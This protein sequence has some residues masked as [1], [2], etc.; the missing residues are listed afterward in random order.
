MP[1][2]TDIVKAMKSNRSSLPVS[3]ILTGELSLSNLELNKL[4]FDGF[5][6]TGNGTTQDIVTGIASEDVNWYV[7]V[8]YSIGDIRFTR[9]GFEN[10]DGTGVDL[11]AGAFTLWECN[12][13]HTSGTT[14]GT[15]LG[16][17]YWT[18][19]ADG[20]SKRFNSSK[21]HIKSRSLATNNFVFDSIRGKLNETN[22]NT[23]DAETVLVSSLTSFNATGFSVGLALGVNENLET[24]IAYQTLYT[25]IVCGVTN[26]GKRYIEAF[27]PVTNETMI[28][29]QGSGIDGHEIPQST[30]VA[31]DLVHSKDLDDGLNDWFVSGVELNGNYLATN[32]TASILTTGVTYEDNTITLTAGSSV[33][34]SGNTCISYG[35]AKSKTWT[36]VEYTGTGATGNFVRTL[37][38]EGN[39]RRPA[40]VIIKAVSAVGSWAVIDNKRIDNEIFLDLSNAEVSTNTL[41][42]VY[43]GFNI[44][45]TTSGTNTL[46]T[47]YIALVEFDT[48]ATG[49]DGSYFDNPTDTTN[50]QLLNGNVSFSNGYNAQ[51]A[52]NT[53]LPLNATVTPT[54]GF[55]AGN[56]YIKIKSDGTSIST[57]V[58]PTFGKISTLSDY[59]LNGVWYDLNGTPLVDIVTYADEVVEANLNGEPVD[60]HNDFI[61][62][63]IVENKILSKVAEIV[64]LTGRW[65]E[66]DLEF[67]EV[68]LNNGT[69][70]FGSNAD[71]FYGLYPDGRAV[72]GH[73]RFDTVNATTASGVLFR[74]AFTNNWTFPFVFSSEAIDAKVEISD[75]TGANSYVFTAKVGRPSSTS[76]R[77]Y[78][79][80]STKSISGLSIEIT[81]SANGFH[82]RIPTGGI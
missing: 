24:Y 66:R 78:D 3:K 2:I 50:L 68:L 41:D 27:N 4:G 8:A 82:N 18:A 62:P 70:I 77:I 61:V 48:D 35:K 79:Y 32:N 29:Y 23:T 46:G 59:L 22:T 65:H 39:E 52:V 40:R 73:T 64:S 19:I 12:T 69:A 33:N 71:G 30:G 10:M 75:S 51:G 37:D 76:N 58:K 38:S 15:M 81:L 20:V 80:F 26:H 28:M 63:D 1:K 54:N 25:N 56:N 72:C 31:L 47:K 14:A 45:S 43:N 9:S 53:V 42:T 74:T 17:A 67:G 7:G 16:D 57:T 11:T 5:L 21:V 60:I 34:V 44:I 49:T 55:S 6:Y 36:I 13:A